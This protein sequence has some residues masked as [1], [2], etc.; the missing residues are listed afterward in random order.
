MAIVTFW[1]NTEKETAQTLSMIAIA[2]HIAVENNSKILI[3]DT[4]FD[5][6]TIKNAYW[7][8]TTNSTRKIIKELSG[9]KLD[10]GSGIEG[11]SKVIASGR[12]AGNVISDYS[13]VVFKG[14]L[15]AILSYVGGNEDDKRR[16]KSEYKEL[17]KLASGQYDYVFVD[18]PKGLTDPFVN[19]ILNMSDV[20]VYNITQR[21]KDMDDYIKLK[22]ENPL[23]KTN[24]ILPLIGRYDKFSKYTKKNIARYLGEKKEIPAVS[25]N[26]LFF[27]SANEGGIGNYFLKFRK[28]LISSSDRN[29]SFIDEVGNASERLI[30][31]TQEVL[32]MR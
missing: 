13:R 22:E 2:S 26:T 31:K 20:I 23:F 18:I 12:S 19:E 7:Q 17:I 11:L 3:I 5:D 32:M 24:K 27:E 1:S 6:T 28:S 16:I 15:E 25:Y 21:L 10:I 8:E 9:G 29:A 30:L 4:N 14:R